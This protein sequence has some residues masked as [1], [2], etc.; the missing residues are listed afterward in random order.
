MQGVGDGRFEPEKA[1]T[2]A[3]FTVIAM[4]FARPKSVDT[5]IFPD[6]KREDW[7]YDEVVSAVCYGWINGYADGTFRPQ[8][9]ISRAEVA[10]ITNRML[11]RMADQA[12]VDGHVDELTRFTDVS[13]YYWAYYDIMEA[14]NAHDVAKENGTERW[15]GLR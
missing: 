4:R 2:R 13:P 3:E 14:A 5:D 6:V 8:N 12:F 1:I 10:A 15:T 9:N 7:F 11:G